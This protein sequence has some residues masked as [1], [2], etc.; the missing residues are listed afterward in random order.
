MDV[1]LFDIEPPPPE[2]QQCT[3]CGTA[4]LACHEELRVLGWLVYDGLSFTSQPMHVR[5][6]PDCQRSERTENSSAPQQALLPP[7]KA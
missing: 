5:T 7:P 3:A 6:C 4:V 1:P 2:A